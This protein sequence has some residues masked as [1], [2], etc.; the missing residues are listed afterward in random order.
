MNLRLVVLLVLGLCP[1]AAAGQVK[2]QTIPLSAASLPTRLFVQKGAVVDIQGDLP[3][4]TLPSTIQIR[5][6]IRVRATG[7]FQK[8]WE[9]Q[10]DPSTEAGDFVALNVVWISPNGSEHRLGHISVE[11]INKV[12]FTVDAPANGAA[13]TGPFKVHIGPTGNLRADSYTLYVDGAPTSSTADASGNGTLDLSSVRPGDHTVGARVMV[14]DGG[15]LDVSPIHVQTPA[16]VRLAPLEVHGPIDLRNIAPVLPLKVDAD[17]G[18]S[19]TSIAFFVDDKPLVTRQAPDFYAALDPSNLASGQHRL[20]ADVIA[21]GG[22]QYQSPY[23]VFS[24]IGDPRKEFTR[25]KER[26]DELIAEATSANPNTQ[27]AQAGLPGGQPM[28][29]G[30]IGTG[31]ALGIIPLEKYYNALLKVAEN[32]EKIPI[33]PSFSPADR[34]DLK[35]ALQLY[36]DGYGDLAKSTMMSIQSI[37]KNAGIPQGAGVVNDQTSLVNLGTL[38]CDRAGELISGVMHRLR[39]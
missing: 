1:V 23:L 36:R 8:H 34:E 28:S 15:E 26:V 9:L 39:L 17:A 11:I 31:S 12:P 24:V 2:P 5:S 21:A 3:D 4:A 10:W 20:S 6:G 14:T 37:T 35:T 27:T 29:R 38:D 22:K 18:I 30:G 33:P 16:K 25:W 13:V 19:I 7:T 32:V